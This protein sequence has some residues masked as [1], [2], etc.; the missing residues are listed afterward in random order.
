MHRMHRVHGWVHSVIPKL[1]PHEGLPV[2]PI[3]TPESAISQNT[4]V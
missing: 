4:N 2:T 3:S 1:S